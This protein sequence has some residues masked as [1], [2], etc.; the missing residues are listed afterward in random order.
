MTTAIWFFAFAAIVTGSIAV[1]QRQDRTHAPYS[2]IRR[3]RKRKPLPT[4]VTAYGRTFVRSST[5]QLPI[6]DN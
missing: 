6:C 5:I 2:R 1:A 4:Y 3:W